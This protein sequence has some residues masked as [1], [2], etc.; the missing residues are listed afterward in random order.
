MSSMVEYY[1]CVEILLHIPL[2]KA[3]PFKECRKVYLNMV[4]HL[5]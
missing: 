4:G 5:L 2:G 3:E 1:Y